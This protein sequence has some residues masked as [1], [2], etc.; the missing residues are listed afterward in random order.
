MDDQTL[1][2]FMED[3]SPIVIGVVLIIAAAWVINVVVKAF[4]EKSITKTKAD[5]L[6]SSARQIRRC[7]RIRQLS[8]KRHRTAVCRG[9][10]GSKHCADK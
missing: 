10:Y 8:G 4:K 3:L 9:D 1:H 7:R 6:Q 2:H 5:L